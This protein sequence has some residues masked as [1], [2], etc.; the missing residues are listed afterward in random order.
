MA[1]SSA[2]FLLHAQYH[3]VDT[4]R[5]YSDSVPRFKCTSCWI[6]TFDPDWGIEDLLVL[7]QFMRE[8]KEMGCYGIGR[9]IH[10]AIL[11]SPTLATI[12]AIP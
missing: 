9:E 7:S 3:G 11:G 4:T 5:H 6:R 10:L 8:V 2:G 12:T 1:R